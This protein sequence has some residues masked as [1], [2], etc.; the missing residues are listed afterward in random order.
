MSSG[1]RGKG[2]GSISSRV[3]T[4]FTSRVGE[5]RMEFKKG[6]RET[7]QPQKERTRGQREKWF[8]EYGKRNREEGKELRQ[9][10][11][12]HASA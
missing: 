9:D 6:M 12:K 8:Q 3:A 10:G 7:N 11:R 1:S 4:A 2:L 5:K